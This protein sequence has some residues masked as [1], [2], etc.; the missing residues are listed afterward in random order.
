MASPLLAA[1]SMNGSYSPRIEPA[2]S[3]ASSPHLSLCTRTDDVSKS[4]GL[5][6]LS[7]YLPRRTQKLTDNPVQSFESELT[8]DLRL[9]APGLNTPPRGQKFLGTPVYLA[10]ES[11]LGISGDDAAVDWVR[12]FHCTFGLNNC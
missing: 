8:N 5:D 4:S 12:R 9:F 2:P 10:P 1:D 3:L 7:G 11:I 6:S